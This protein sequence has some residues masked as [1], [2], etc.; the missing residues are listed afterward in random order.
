M[1]LLKI[2]AVALLAAVSIV[3]V[4][5]TS[6]P[7]TLPPINEFYATSTNLV[8]TPAAYS[9][10]FVPSRSG[11][12]GAAA[13]NYISAGT[14]SNNA[15]VYFWK[16]T[17]SSSIS[18]TNSTTTL[19]PRDTNGF[20]TAT[21]VM[22]I[23]HRA[24]VP[25]T[26]EKRVG[27][28]IVNSTNLTIDVACNS[29]VIP[30]DVIYTVNVGGKVPWALLAGSAGTNSINSASGWFYVGQPGLPVMVE[31]GGATSSALITGVSGRYLPAPIVPRPGL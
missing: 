23:E 21:E 16:V 11:N 20:P 2:L 15:Y 12:G 28:T 27:A 6:V 25:F 17:A 8:T 26:Y 10:A 18:T 4:E 22:I 3:S 9:F 30:G 13:I 1:K 24:T 31:I 19:Y 7:T 29:A 5:A 14:A